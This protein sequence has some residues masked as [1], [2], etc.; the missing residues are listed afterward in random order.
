MSKLIESSQI[1]QGVGDAK[2][3]AVADSILIGVGSQKSLSKL[4]PFFSVK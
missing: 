3:D 1:S 2:T 4:E